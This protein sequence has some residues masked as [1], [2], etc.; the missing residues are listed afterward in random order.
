MRTT[1]VSE[2]TS[3]TL[4]DIKHREFLEAL[5]RHYIGATVTHRLICGVIF[6]TRLDGRDTWAVD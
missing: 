5:V 3:A 1:F 4:L 6:G 2:L